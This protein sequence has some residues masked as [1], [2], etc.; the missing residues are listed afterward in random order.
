[1][2]TQD[3]LYAKEESQSVV[4]IQCYQMHIIVTEA[5]VI[6]ALCEGKYLV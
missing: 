2:R 6:D 1:L 3:K 5:V 4:F